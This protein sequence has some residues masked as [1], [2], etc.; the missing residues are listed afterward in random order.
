MLDRTPGIE[1]QE[2][3]GDR[4]RERAGDRARP[5][6]HQNERAQVRGDGRDQP[7][8]DQGLAEEPEP[9]GEKDREQRRAIVDALG[10]AGSPPVREPA[11]G[12]EQMIKFVGAWLVSQ[13]DEQEREREA[14]HQDR[15]KPG[16]SS[17]LHGSLV[18]H[19]GRA[20]AFRR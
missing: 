20:G 4:R 15:G 2:H 10:D 14:P 13:I 18:R 7:A 19:G 8:D 3:G 6:E 17:A 11:L 1:C 5:H 12:G 9:L 16:G